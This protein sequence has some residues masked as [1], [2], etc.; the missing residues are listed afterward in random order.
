MAVDGV[1]LR[2]RGLARDIALR[3]LPG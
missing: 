2:Q 1:R 3:L